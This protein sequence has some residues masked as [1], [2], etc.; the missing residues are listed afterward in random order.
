MTFLSG[1]KTYII[2]ILMIAVGVV[3]GLTGDASA[4]QGVMDNAMIILN[5][6]GFAAV[7]AGIAS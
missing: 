2:A 7:R 1:K 4:W 6:A 5:G 3:Q